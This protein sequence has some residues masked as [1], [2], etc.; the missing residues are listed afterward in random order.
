ANAPAQ[1][2]APPKPKTKTISTELK[3]E[4]R[5]PVV[6]D[7]D[8]Y[9]RAEMKMQEA[10]L[11]EKQKADAKNSVEE[12]VYDMRDKLSDSLAEFVTEKDAEALRSQLTA[13]E[14]WLY[15]EGEDAEK[16]V[17]EQRLAELRKLGDPIIERYREFEARKPA[18]EAFDRSIIRVR[19]AYEDYVA[20]GEAHA[21]IDSA[22]MEKV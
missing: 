20:G 21:H 3:I 10:D 19:K 7:I 14:D 11:H 4:E 13:V 9:T 22:D 16:P 2:S 8:K 5:L 17:Y 15:D 12:Y 1:P 18:F 6:Y